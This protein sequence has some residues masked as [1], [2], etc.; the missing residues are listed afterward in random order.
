MSKQY[1]DIYNLLQIDAW[2]DPFSDEDD[3]DK[4]MWTWNQSFFI[5]RVLVREGADV[6]RALL[7]ALHNEG[8]KLDRGVW[9]VEDDDNYVTLVRRKDNMPLFALEYVPILD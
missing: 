9:R 5:K 3:N 8:V 4:P 1:H 7:R 2:I 6:K